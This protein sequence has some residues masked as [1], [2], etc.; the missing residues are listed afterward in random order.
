VISDT[1]T[2]NEST[3]EGENYFVSMTD[4]MVGM[5]FIF[6]IMLM[7]FALSLREREDV[8]KS[9]FDE[10]QKEILRV[11]QRVE[12][13]KRVQDARARFLEDLENR[14]TLAGVK[15]KADPAS[16]VLRLPQAI[17]FQS[18]RTDLSVE[19]RI[20]IERLGTVL[21]QVLPCYLSDPAARS[22]D[23]PSVGDVRLESLFLE[24][25]AD[26]S[27]NEQRNWE[28]SVNRA[29]STYRELERHPSR[30]AE[31]RNGSGERLFSVSGYGQ[32]RPVEPN[33]SADG[34][35]ANR[36][37][38]LRFNMQV[39]QRAVLDDI[40]QGLRRLREGR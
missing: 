20:A 35:A 7:A 4:M 21:D 18:D 16:G 3:E 10:L 29:V 24:G 39:D 27:G 5:L 14:L 11:E 12:D 25:H 33:D 13:I 19:G 1:Q 30:V 8:S 38:E 2:S 22:I 23:C 17:L 28:L 26:A 9:K 32:F 15:V 31:L 34:R 37:M 6:I 40:L 36:R